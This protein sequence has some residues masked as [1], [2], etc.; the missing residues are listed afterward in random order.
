ME[1][2]YTTIKRGRPVKKKKERWWQCLV[3]EGG[4]RRLESW[5]RR[6]TKGR[7][8]EH[9]VGKRAGG[10]RKPALYD[11]TVLGVL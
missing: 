7:P 1:E 2:L 10:K 8:R 11:L 4:G 6:R 3:G 5:V 9:G